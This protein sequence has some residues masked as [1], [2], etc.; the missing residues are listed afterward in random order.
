MRL[1]C[2]S[3]G[4]MVRAF[5]GLVVLASA[6]AGV[7]TFS[8][9]SP[10]LLASTRPA[11]VLNL[12]LT[13]TQ[14]LPPVSAAAL[15]AETS[16]IWGGH[17]QLGWLTGDAV[18]DEAT[19][20]RVIVLA[21]AV[22]PA[23]ETSPWTVGEL[24]RME[25]ARALAIASIT[26]ARR[27]VEEARLPLIDL[28]AVHDRR[29]GVVLGRAVAHEIGHYLLRTSTHASHGLMRARI[30]AREFADLRSGPFR[31]DVAA[32]AHMATLAAGGALSNAETFSYST[33]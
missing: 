24:V 30:D 5:A 31:L 27:I 18:D 22:P 19:T 28:P 6:V 12:R 9:D 11:L 32:Q 25:G 8:A 20:L 17:I 23:G 10:V 13:S 15:M 29:L 14:V 4:V 26:G 3:T 1:Y 21:R 16:A 2:R 33:H 7:S